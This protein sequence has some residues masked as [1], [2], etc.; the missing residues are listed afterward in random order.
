[1]RYT[2]SHVFKSPESNSEV[3]ILQILCSDLISRNHFFLYPEHV[4]NSFEKEVKM[5][6]IYILF[7][8]VQLILVW[9]VRNFLIFSEFSQEC[10]LFKK[11]LKSRICGHLLFATDV[12]V[13]RHLEF[14]LKI[15]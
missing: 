6:I 15:N 10:K 12:F 3:K 13:R 11:R 8:K 9:A 4:L 1:M 7:S 14:H 2:W 5:K